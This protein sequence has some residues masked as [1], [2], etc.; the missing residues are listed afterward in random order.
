MAGSP[1]QFIIQFVGDNASLT[2]SLK[3]N[4][5]QLEAFKK[6]AMEAGAEV[7]KSMAMQ[8]KGATAAT[9]SINALGRAHG[10]VN[11][12][13]LATETVFLAN[14][15]DKS[16]GI[17][18]KKYL[19]SI[20][21]L[22]E[23]LYRFKQEAKDTIVVHK[24]LVTTLSDP[25]LQKSVS[26]LQRNLIT[27][28]IDNMGQSMIS[29]GKN[30]QW[31]GRQLMVGLTAPIVAIGA[32]SVKSAQQIDLADLAI[33]KLIHNGVGSLPLLNAAMKSLDDQSKKLSETFGVTRL[34]VKNMQ[35]EFA[36]VGF[37]PETIRQLTDLTTKF[38]M[39]GRLDATQAA[40]F[41][42]VLKQAG[43]TIPQV[44]DTLQ[45]LNL[46]ENETALN[47]QDIVGS[48]SS[49]FP[50]MRQ[51]NV[52][53]TETVAVLSIFKQS[54]V[55][56]S[57]GVSA[58]KN[59]LTKMPAVL[60]MLDQGT[61]SGASRLKFL[62][63]TL[64]SVNAQF[65]TGFSLIDPA[66]K[67]MRTGIDLL[68]QLGV[69]YN[70]MKNSQS[71][72]GDD[73]IQ[74]LNRALG[75]G[76][77]GNNVAV[78]FDGIGKSLNAGTKSA[79]D[80]YKNMQI[81]ED[82]SANAAKV[83]SE[84]LAIFTGDPGIV[85]QSKIN[86]LINVAQDLGRQLIPVVT[87]ILD[88]F[89]ALVDR[90]DTLGEGSKKVVLG[91]AAAAAVLGPLIYMAGQF[92]IAGGVVMRGLIAPF[93][94]M[95]GVNVRLRE[96]FKGTKD[97][98]FQ[99]DNVMTEL[100]KTGDQAKAIADFT[101]LTSTIKT[102]VQSTQ[103]ATAAQ[104][105]LG[106]ATEKTAREIWNETEKAKA[107]GM[108]MQEAIRP[109]K[110]GIRNVFST[111]NVTNLA[112]MTVDE[113]VPS[114]G[115]A[116][117]V[118]QAKYVARL[119]QKALVAQ[120]RAMMKTDTVIE[121][122]KTADPAAMMLLQERLEK[123]DQTVNKLT[124]A[125]MLKLSK[126]MGIED[127]GALQSTMKGEAAYLTS[128]KK[129]M[130]G[131]EKAFGIQ[132][133]IVPNIAIEDDM[134]RLRDYGS[135]FDEFE[136][137]IHQQ[138][139]QIATNHGATGRGLMAAFGLD[140]SAVQ[141]TTP[142]AEIQKIVAQAHRGAPE[143]MM[144]LLTTAIK[145]GDARHNLAGAQQGSALMKAFGLNTT[146]IDRAADAIITEY[147]MQNPGTQSFAQYFKDM[148][149]MGRRPKLPIRGGVGEGMKSGIALAL[150]DVAGAR[151]GAGVP[152]AFTGRALEQIREAIL[153]G[154]DL[155]KLNDVERHIVTE[156]NE[157]LKIVKGRMNNPAFSGNLFAG[158]QAKVQEL[159]ADSRKGVGDRTTEA[160]QASLEKLKTTL[161]KIYQAQADHV[162]SVLTH[163]DNTL[164]RD[165]ISDDMRGKV[166][167]VK[168]RL[169]AK[170]HK[171]RG[172]LQRM[173]EAIN[174]RNFVRAE[175]LTEFK[176]LFGDIERIKSHV[177]VG[178]KATTKAL[179]IPDLGSKVDEMT[180]GMLTKFN[181]SQ[182]AQVGER[183][184]R[185]IFNTEYEKKLSA[186]VAKI[187]ARA[188]NPAELTAIEDHIKVLEK[189]RAKIIGRPL[190]EKEQASIRA[191]AEALVRER[192]AMSVELTAAEVKAI[193]TKATKVAN[194]SLEGLYRKQNMN[195]GS[196]EQRLARRE[197]EGLGDTDPGRG[198]GAAI[199][200]E[201]TYVAQGR[202]TAFNKAIKKVA[203]LDPVALMAEG[204]KI[205]NGL[206]GEFQV[207]EEEVIAEVKSN[208]IGGFERNQEIKAKNE[209]IVARNAQARATA[210][211]TYVK[212]ALASTNK[213]AFMR[214]RGMP[215]EI[216]SAVTAAIFGMMQQED[217]GSVGQKNF[218][219]GYGGMLRR[220]MGKMYSEEALALVNQIA[221]ALGPANYAEQGMSSVAG[222]TVADTKT[223]Q[224]RSRA[225]MARAHPPEVGGLTGARLRTG[226]KGLVAMK[227]HEVVAQAKVFIEENAAQLRT[228][229][230]E[231]SGLVAQRKNTDEFYEG[232]LSN[233]EYELF[234]QDALIRDLSLGAGFAG[235]DQGRAHI[236]GLKASIAKKVNGLGGQISEMQQLSDLRALMVRRK[237]GGASDEEFH[238]MLRSTLGYGQG[239]GEDL[240][241][242]TLEREATERK[243]VLEGRLKRIRYALEKSGAG[244]RGELGAIIN[245][246]TVQVNSERQQLSGIPAKL[247]TKR[248]ELTQ[249]LFDINK[250]MHELNMALWTRG[251]DDKLPARD[252]MYE[253]LF[254]D[255]GLQALQQV[256]DHRV[257][258]IKRVDA[259]INKVIKTLPAGEQA[260]A[261]LAMAV[262]RERVLGG[263]KST[264]EAYAGGV[265]AQSDAA[266]AS[267]KAG[268]AATKAGGENIHG[269][270]VEMEGLIHANTN[271]LEGDMAALDAAMNGMF[272]TIQYGK[273][274]P[275]AGKFGRAT[276]L[277]GFHAGPLVASL[278]PE[279]AQALHEM[280]VFQV[281]G[282]LAS[283]DGLI[284]EDIA[285]AVSII[286][287]WM[288]SIPEDIAAEYAR[289][290]LMI[291]RAMRAD[292]QKA[293][294]V[295]GE[296]LMAQMAAAGKQFG[297]GGELGMEDK[298]STMTRHL[299]P[300]QGTEFALRRGNDAELSSEA[301]QAKY[302]REMHAKL[303]ANY[304]APSA[305]LNVIEMG[306]TD[307]ASK[308]NALIKANR[309]MK[310]IE[311]RIQECYVKEEEALAS[312]NR[313]IRNAARR[314]RAALEKELTAAKLI[315]EQ[316][317]A[318]MAKIQTVTKLV[319]QDTGGGTQ[320][321]SSY[322]EYEQHRMQQVMALVGHIDEQ[323]AFQFDVELDAKGQEELARTMAALE[324]EAKRKQEMETAINTEIRDEAAL[325]TQSNYEAQSG[326]GRRLVTALTGRKFAMGPT[327]SIILAEMHAH[328]VAAKKDIA[329][330]RASEIRNFTKFKQQ[331]E[332]LAQMFAGMASV[333][334]GIPVAAPA[335]PLGSL[336]GA[337]SAMK[338]TIVAVDEAT[339]ATGRL[340]RSMTGRMGS[341]M[342][343]NSLLDAAMWQGMSAGADGAAAS[344]GGLSGA[345]AGFGQLF[346]KFPMMI[347]FF[348]MMSQGIGAVITKTGPWA[349]AI[350][351]VVAAIV[352]IALHWKDV[353]KGM[354][355]GIAHITDGFQNLADV[356]S[357]PF[358]SII[359][360]GG[361]SVVEGKSVS[362]TWKNVGSSFNGLAHGL[363]SVLN[364]LAAV[365]HP[366]MVVLTGALGVLGK[367]LSLF[368][369]LPGPVQTLA[370]AIGLFLLYLRF[371]PVSRFEMALVSLFQTM[372]AEGV[373]AGLAKLKSL[374][375]VTN[376]AMGVAA[377]GLYV[378]GQRMQN[379]AAN[380]EKGR[381]AWMDFQD[382][383]NKKFDKG[384]GDTMTE[385]EAQYN[386]AQTRLADLKN[387]Y[388]ELLPQGSQSNLENAGGYLST[389]TGGHL[390][391]T[392][393]EIKAA[394]DALANLRAEIE[395]G[396]AEAA[397]KMG[398]YENAKKSTEA[399]GASLGITRQQIEDFANA[400]S[401]LMTE[402]PETVIKKFTD[403]WNAAKAAGNDPLQLNV[404]TT[405]MDEAK[406]KLSSFISAWQSQ[407]QKIM[408][409]WKA[410]AMSAFD[411][412]AKAQINAID[413][414]IKALDKQ[415]KA[416]A[417]HQ[418]DLDYLQKKEENRAKRRTENIK[419]SAA[420]DLAI[421]EG[422]YDDAATLT[423]DHA[424]SLAEMAA[425]EAQLEK[426]RQQTLT[427]RARAAE[428]ERLNNAKDEMQKEIDLKKELLQQE[429]DAMT[430]YL[431]RNV[432][433]AAAMHDAILA[434][435]GEYTGGY[436]DIGTAHM[437][438]W[439]KGWDDAIG[440][441]KKDIDQQMW[442]AG[443]EAMNMFAAA[444]G[445][446]P[447]DLAK[448]TAPT[449]TGT[450]ATPSSNPGGMKGVDG[451]TSR[452]QGGMIGTE[453]SSPADVQ[454]TLQ[455][456]EY[457]MRRAAVAKH[458]AGF[459]D[460]INRGDTYHAGGLV[461]D[462]AYKAMSNSVTGMTNK[463]FSGDGKIANWSKADLDAEYRSRISQATGGSAMAKVIIDAAMS[464]LGVPYL[465]GGTNP[466]IGLDCSGL[467]LRAYEAA[468]ISLPRVSQDQAKQGTEATDGGKPADIVYFGK[469]AT[470]VGLNLGDGKMIDAPHTG[471]VVR[472]ENIW[473]NVSG[474]R[475]ILQDF[476]SGSGGG[477]T[478]SFGPGSPQ[479]KARQAL[480]DWGWGPE[481][482]GGL[483]QL[484]TH[485]SGWRPDAK[486]PT[487]DAA[488]LF[489]FMKP[490][491]A[492]Y[493]ASKGGP[494]Y[495]SPDVDWEIRGGLDY[496]KGRYGSPNAAWDF[497]QSRQPINGKDVGN[498]YHQGGSV[499]PVPHMSNGGAIAASG[500]A[501]V[502]AGETV[503]TDKLSRAVENGDFGGGMHLD[504]HFDG[505]YFG[506]D[507]ELEK[508]VDTIET[509]IVPKLQRARGQQNRTFTK[510]TK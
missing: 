242:A 180:Q 346:N 280:V 227:R 7:Q 301:A 178:G 329:E 103:E 195:I 125:E 163:L 13:Q 131:F 216:R 4:T 74:I 410:A 119:Q 304:L 9:A 264:T 17:I 14:A 162:D 365:L 279:M 273:G 160:Q 68:E 213:H 64:V 210:I 481:Q 490:T 124:N 234:N 209:Q 45:R 52:S 246:L 436:Q 89:G 360:W 220:S 46:M 183:K 167:A 194:A 413:I 422:R 275:Q 214:S 393:A 305:I 458:G 55:E 480:A 154:A 488:G 8:T 414:Q 434:K 117:P 173:S 116:A 243:A 37:D 262:E 455:T 374:F 31:T 312:H 411:D 376:V 39:L 80:F 60:A 63:D 419:F 406:S 315:Q 184:F 143:A 22:R 110:A 391:R 159:A 21:G 491:W 284:K 171:I 236:A 427:D 477:G 367:F 34:E 100:R 130:I 189:G 152:R 356:I 502:H 142:G 67:R 462:L 58:L 241:L 136:K 149:A 96:V 323:G 457:V 361:K 187:E 415:A 353:Q 331:A 296:S 500:L 269:T 267:V 169:E 437:E 25:A 62:R 48:F 334:G 507:R 235:A 343:I 211:G 433:A 47:M 44:T 126:E 399:L 102:G 430:E 186:K 302:E 49:I 217:I 338:T 319:V 83:W 56:V 442:L 93:K 202:S 146:T 197:L 36:S 40:E 114:V 255:D 431:P 489:Q 85:M 438:A 358:K 66:T 50:M 390:G 94:Q 384:P 276:N 362:T 318:D 416:E 453:D 200:S 121:T 347:S 208:K 188:F 385:L 311:A 72:A 35:Q 161:F 240:Q 261:R 175:D 111:P 469:P 164:Q 336:A 185:T 41:V 383:I 177:T 91:I 151:G 339:A 324:R 341:G 398:L 139:R 18:D 355:D 268:M 404:D 314:R 471:A 129:R 504:L 170:A 127:V 387:Q 444:A 10:N 274:H 400:N 253:M 123:A 424:I 248:E 265:A 325:R 357:K 271:V 252:K 233:L 332:E 354:G 495:W 465:W 263:A 259:E 82:Q 179:S 32:L 104:E 321:F 192:R 256:A 73:M 61:K 84:Q 476:V 322:A 382:V 5:V 107:F 43:M 182:Y 370:T 33:R 335:I 26:F 294:L 328:D 76:S 454:A 281:E 86:H 460:Q 215:P 144:Q 310:D 165:D 266:I 207:A 79:Q 257:S 401:I 278:S 140:A 470:H 174:N 141:V 446:D 298:L 12:K 181:E 381:Q 394:N 11:T 482:W 122:R 150:Q 377:V 65:G 340:K 239:E 351:A 447:K 286:R 389:L 199:P 487:S 20:K 432:A 313:N 485:E 380:V 492:S 120:L 359:D 205:I 23:G 254:G 16:S 157:G 238:T 244:G 308:E 245:Q 461:G 510:V 97:E 222:L 349:I 156:L 225:A 221:A 196:G 6:M 237:A 497:W 333:T 371:A 147:E 498:W 193:I 38:Q 428:V 417:E 166:Q 283:V 297:M 418:Q 24:G 30:A 292:I 499:Y 70:A 412:W 486:N 282:T 176:A 285:D 450:G 440:S 251:P 75:V 54:G 224:D 247:A 350:A 98:A 53:A 320:V 421:Y 372:R 420:R 90:F 405:K 133:P 392:A 137:S 71:A 250:Q 466:G 379:M 1:I 19:S 451:G 429:L 494:S 300:G 203:G 375:T 409:G 337:G 270:L 435:M 99:L 145:E 472:V 368:N 226:D 27:R 59:V 212:E 28:T 378:I 352:G 456:G 452:H 327:E 473:S 366:I 230:S 112:K 293:K 501:Q 506:S 386:A 317:R 508:L 155:E 88:V 153:N 407:M 425:T 101:K 228:L 115:P 342:W 388:N 397:D 295:F 483:D 29:M 464:W 168:T 459:M 77:Q 443:T 191:T 223:F 344:V 463:F 106:V 232:K 15:F 330:Y 448:P 190:N 478:A 479:D 206:L 408:D 51:L 426:D 369:A 172:S 148:A 198:T 449:D 441:A 87:R 3:Q 42:R 316:A 345:M 496:I 57:T 505:G 475:R 303:P 113:L 287:K 396:D 105:E 364:I 290:A 204:D 289:K 249:S 260:M 439:N 348:P 484:V 467:V 95:Y 218:V 258:Q 291:S 277:K 2:S 309:G 132:V 219:E 272:L 326:P 109:G 474:M 306:Q 373:A 307:I 423:E 201:A 363:G 158:V 128:L 403:A 81:A 134:M 509:R 135:R 445:V 468:G 229:K 402:D 138:A 69:A 288:P 493:I 395:R 78:L 118:D 231:L 92:M 503:V 108:A 299:I